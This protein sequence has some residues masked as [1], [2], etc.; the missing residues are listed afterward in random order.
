MKTQAQKHVLGKGEVIESLIRTGVIKSKEK[1]EIF[2]KFLTPFEK[3]VENQRVV[4]FNKLLCSLLLLSKDSIP[5]KVIHLFG[6]YKTSS[7]P[8]VLTR[9]QLC[10]MLDHLVFA[11]IY[12]IPKL[13][14]FEIIK[15][16]GASS[17][18][19]KRIQQ[20]QLEMLKKVRLNKL[21]LI[22]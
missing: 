9:K 4:S 22:S 8:H 2:E 10:V 11:V 13:S 1:K 7:S 15:G 16:F 6:I 17:L 20:I 19:A 12:A 14:Q 3:N 18:N 5:D 21:L